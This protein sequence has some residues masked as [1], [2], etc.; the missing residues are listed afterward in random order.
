MLL[1]AQVARA[2]PAVSVH[3]ASAGSACLDERELTALVQTANWNGSAVLPPIEVSI[4]RRAAGGWVARIAL[5]TAE[6]AGRFE[7]RIETPNNDCRDL[8]EALGLVTRVL[9]ESYLECG[10]GVAVDEAYDAH[11]GAMCYM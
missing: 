5:V 6:T 10:F 1:T 3:L 4:D 9:M 8:D 11:P 2:T 7:Q